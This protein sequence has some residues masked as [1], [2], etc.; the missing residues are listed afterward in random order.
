M[1]NQFPKMREISWIG[2]ISGLVFLMAR[3]TPVTGRALEVGLWMNGCGI[4]TGGE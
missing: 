1:Q 4:V 3:S 2:D